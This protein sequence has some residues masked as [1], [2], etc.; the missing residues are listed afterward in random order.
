[1]APP[2]KI[3]VTPDRTRCDTTAANADRRIPVPSHVSVVGRMNP[4][5]R[6]SSPTNM[7]PSMQSI[8][9]S[10]CVPWTTCGRLKKV[11]VR[12]VSFMRSN[13]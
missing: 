3:G 11:A 8:V 13:G 7:M 1:M 5:P 2:A 6:L 9:A 12:P 10:D 4:K